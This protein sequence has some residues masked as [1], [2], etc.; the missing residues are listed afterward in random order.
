MAKI[1][2]SSEL[3]NKSDP[4]SSTGVFTM[5][6]C[7]IVTLLAIAITCSKSFFHP[8]LSP[9]PSRSSR[10]PQTQTQANTF[11]TINTCR[12]PLHLHSS[13][14]PTPPNPNTPPPFPNSTRPTLVSLRTLQTYFGPNSNKIWGD[15]TNSDTRLLYHSL[16]PRAL[17]KIKQLQASPINQ[18]VSSLANSTSKASL[19]PNTDL[20]SLAYL[21]YSLRQTAKLY[22]RYRCNLPGR[23]LTEIYDGWRHFREYGKW[24]TEGREWDEIWEKYEREINQEL[25][26]TPLQPSLESGQ[27]SDLICLRILERSCA[28][29]SFIDG[30]ILESTDAIMMQD[31]LI[32][33]EMVD[34]FVEGVFD[35]NRRLSA[36]EEVVIM[37]AQEVR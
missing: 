18:T 2:L 36:G 15:L 4:T 32:T 22:S 25:G 6:V 16:L 31:D 20:K 29:N 11:Q 13:F 17:L 12:Q 21:S 10:H 1:S 14:K 30:I 27:I 28:T 26:D 35:S 7:Y 19:G 37:L 24:N 5:R 3:T 8:A 9:H 23:V 34:T 33:D